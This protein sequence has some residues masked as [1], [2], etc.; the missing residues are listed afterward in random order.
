MSA[1]DIYSSQ[2]GARCRKYRAAYDSPEAK[3]WIASLTPAQREHAERLGLL[4]PFIGDG[5]SSPG[6][7][8]DDMSNSVLTAT[9]DHI[10]DDDTPLIEEG[11]AAAL[12]EDGWIAMFRDL[13]NGNGCERARAFIMRG[14]NPRLRWAC[15]C[16]MLGEAPLDTLAKT[17][18]MSKQAFHYHVRQ[19]QLELGIR[20]GRMAS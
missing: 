7:S 3:A 11:S 20:H 10:Q 2:F 4:Q 9:T 14:G 8:F 12:G 15:V 6:P 5:G 19:L 1:R 16:Y 17:V 18:S 13:R